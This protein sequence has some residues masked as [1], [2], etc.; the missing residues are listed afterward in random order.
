MK[1]YPVVLRGQTKH[2][3]LPLAACMLEAWVK[4]SFDLTE[5]EYEELVD[6]VI[7]LLGEIRNERYRFRAK[8]DAS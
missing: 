8:P 6:A 1:T 2:V 5:D 3:S 7:E 4:G